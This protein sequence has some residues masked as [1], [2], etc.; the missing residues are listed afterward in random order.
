[1]EFLREGVLEA[2]RLIRTLDPDVLSAALVSIR[3]ATL[4]TLL[5]AAIGVPIGFVL[6]TLDFPGR[7]MAILSFNSLLGV[8]TVLIGLLGIGLLSRQGPLGT[9]N[10]LFTPTG[11]VLGTT[12]LAIPILVVFTLAPLKALSP[13]VRETARTLGASPLMVAWTLLR[14]A[15]HGFMAAIVA[16]FGRIISEVGIAMMLGGNIKGFTRTLTTA[17]ALETN[18]GL[19]GLGLA[20]GLI[21]LGIGVVVSLALTQIQGR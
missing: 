9:L 5:A 14:E 4:S 8:P 18:K 11:M 19:F 21:L 6:A 12:F 13:L 2:L 16:G 1:M 10:L 20:L 7:R 3:L 15:R 17:I